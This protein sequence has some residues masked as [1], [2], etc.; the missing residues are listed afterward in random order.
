MRIPMISAAILMAL[1]P[2]A[3]ISSTEPTHYMCGGLYAH[4]NGDGAWEIKHG[5]E[6]LFTHSGS[7]S[8]ADLFDHY[9]D[10]EGH[11][12]GASAHWSLH[13]D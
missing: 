10:P 12:T 1:S 2:A 6:L 3:A 4:L 7:A 8:R 9:C 5:A 13:N 11:H